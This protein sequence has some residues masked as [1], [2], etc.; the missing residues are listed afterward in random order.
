MRARSV[1]GMRSAGLSPRVF[2][3]PV[4]AEPSVTRISRR[5]LDTRAAGELDKHLR[6]SCGASSGV[7][8]KEVGRR[9][10]PYPC[11]VSCSG[12][13]QTG[14]HLFAGFE[15]DPLPVHVLGAPDAWSSEVAWPC[16][17]EPPAPTSLSGGSMSGEGRSQ[18]PVEAVETSHAKAR[19]GSPHR[20]RRRRCSTFCGECARRPAT[21]MPTSLSSARLALRTLAD[22]LNP[23]SPSRMRQLQRSKR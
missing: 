9:L 14:S 6:K 21:R 23:W 4:L 10:F 13:P 16:G 20:W 18:M 15:V 5:T 3:P 8:G 19:I 7:I 1:V 2:T 17:S 11:N 12:C 22:S